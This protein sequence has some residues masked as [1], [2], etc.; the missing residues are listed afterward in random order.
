L[1][2]HRLLASFS[3]INASSALIVPP[4]STGS[5]GFTR[6]EYT[7][8]HPFFLTPCLPPL[9][10]LRVFLFIQIIPS[11][12]GH[13]SPCVLVGLLQPCG[14]WYFFPLSSCLSCPPQE[15]GF[16][17]FWRDDFSP[18]LLLSVPEVSLLQDRLDPLIYSPSRTLPVCF[19]VLALFFLPP[20]WRSL[21]S[22]C[23][24]PPDDWTITSPIPFFRP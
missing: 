8:R 11:P 18:L 14:F 13:F 23:R 7:S 3:F 17:P 21:P 15:V 1:S 9:N 2:C 19:T 20:S 24:P 10:P 16:F 5:S 12:A 22:T 6:V 4:F